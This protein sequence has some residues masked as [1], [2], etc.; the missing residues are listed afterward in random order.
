MASKATRHVSHAASDPLDQHSQQPNATHWPQ[1]IPH[2]AGRSLS[3]VLTK[4]LGLGKF[5]VQ[6]QLT[7]PEA[8]LN[9]SE[10]SASCVLNLLSSGACFPWLHCPAQHLK[11]PPTILPL[12]LQTQTE[13]FSPFFTS[14][15]PSPS[16][17]HFTFKRHKWV[18]NS[19][20]LH[21][22]TTVFLVD[23]WILT[24][25]STTFW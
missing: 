17:L 14:R 25:N 18:I 15:C 4:F 10:K 3:R 19:Y 9:Y 2:G 7:R 5:V 21:F 23:L 1:L 11:P 8:H 13:N 12:Y 16:L 6:R 24:S 22:C 20:S